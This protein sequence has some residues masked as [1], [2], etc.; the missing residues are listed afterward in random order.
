MANQEKGCR[1]TFRKWDE[2]FLT[3][4]NDPIIQKFNKSFYD[5]LVRESIQNSMDA[6]ADKSKPVKVSYTFDKISVDEFPA[7]FG[8]REHVKG[9]L[10][11]YCDKPRGKELYGPML[12]YLPTDPGGYVDL[13][14]VSDYNTCGMDYEPGNHD[15]PFF[16]FTK[17]VGLSV[18]KSEGSGGSF[19]LGKAAYFLMSPLRTILVSS[20]TPSGKAHFEG[21]SRLAVHTVGDVKYTDVGFYDNDEGNPVS[22]DDIPEKFRRSAPGTSISLL[23]KHS[24]LGSIAGMQEELVIAV[25][26]NYWLSIYEGKLE[27]SIANNINLTR[28]SLD[29][30]MKE[31]F[32]MKDTPHKFSPR[33]YYDAYSHSEDSAHLKFEDETPLLGKVQLYVRVS[34]DVKTDR[35]CYMRKPLML[36]Q[37][38]NVG[39]SYGLNALFLCLDEK[40]NGLLSDIEDAS[41][42][43]WSTSGKTGEYLT[44]AK[45]VLDEINEF[46]KACLKDAF[47]GDQDIEVVDIGLGYSEKDIENLLGSSSENN[48]PF[49]TV[50][51][52]N[53][54]PEGGALT[55]AKKDDGKKSGE[56]SSKGNVGKGTKGEKDSPAAAR[57]T[58]GTGRGRG[59][60]NH[61]GGE[62]GAGRNQRTATP[63]EADK[64]REFT[65]YVPTSYH[66]PAYKEN[67]EWFHDIILEVSERLE[68]AFIEIKVGTDDGKADTVAISSTSEGRVSAA[69]RG[70]IKFDSLEKGMHK[71]KVQF[72]DKQRHTIKLR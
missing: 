42:T 47:A 2:W 30:F 17:S 54:V 56:K 70:V 31:Y 20:M 29:R 14:T 44:R 43:S 59:K 15:T 48:N 23:G 28:T 55:T 68:N 53:V 11:T 67:G 35:I 41:H 33:P 36:V 9:C 65:L 57:K 18:K 16:A 3:G 62:P 66:A 6:V 58:I 25:L 64:G 1:W 5:S 40:G 61:N 8:L 19:G 12:D 71:I 45:A 63:E 10:E 69:E 49:G 4:N 72:K 22:G 27:V 7:L 38:K 26:K 50:A 34:S 13:I 51:T 60:S 52:G 37:T 32:P 24:D 39:T 46:V 21:V